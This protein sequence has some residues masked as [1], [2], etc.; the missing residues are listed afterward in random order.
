MFRPAFMIMAA[1]PVLAWSQPTNYIA[2]AGYS[3][4]GTGVAPG[5]VVTLF[6]RGLNVPNAV[7]NTVPLPRTLSGV[8]VVVT[9]P[10]T[11]NYPTTLPIFSVQSSPDS[12][13]GGL[14]T[15]C[16][17]TEV[18]VQI[19]FE[20]TCIPSGFP[21]SCTIGDHPPVKIA[22]ETNAGTGQEF[23]FGVV[24]QNPHFLNSCDTV[25]GVFGLNPICYPIVTHADGSVL[26]VST[27]ARAGEEIV[28]Y[29]VGLGAT[30]GGGQTG[31]AA[32]S[33]DPLPFDFYLSWGYFVDTPPGS[34]GPPPKIVQSGQWIKAD[35]A[36]L[37][38]GFVGLYQVNVR[39]PDPL[40]TGIHQCQGAA[41]T[42]L[43]LLVGQAETPGNYITS[44]DICVQQ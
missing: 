30:H 3:L 10:P 7:A 25:F 14:T 41:D 15:F 34:P 44:I 24:T 18:T 12:C 28:L 22:V 32:A 11:P 13:G 35:Y 4:P 27:P 17:T 31:S 23:W 5:Q 9:N 36:G 43:R 37:V 26:Y 20:G 29:A 16:N 21:N 2:A 42:N 39:L 40:P 8:T 38:K 33:P 6:V 1:F 19:P